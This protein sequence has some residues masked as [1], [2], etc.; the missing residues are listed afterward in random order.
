M[1]ADIGIN[2]EQKKAVFKVIDHSDKM[3]NSEWEQYATDLGINKKQLDGLKKILNDENL[4]Q[5]SEDMK[6]LFAALK[7]L[8]VDEFVRFDAHIIRGLDYYTGTVFEANDLD[9]GRALLGGGH[10]DNLVEAV[11]GEPLPAVGFAMGDV[12]ITLVLQKYGLLP[13]LPQY[14]NTCLVTVF[15]ENSLYSSY[16][17][18]AQLRTNGINTI[19]YPSAAKLL[20][21]LKFAD[22]LG[23]RY[24]ILQGT[25]EKEQGTIA[26]K[27]LKTHQQQTLPEAQFPETLKKMM[28]EEL[29]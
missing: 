2:G 16:R 11:G 4:W 27:D 1:L 14:Q 10:Y 17:L 6:R 13:E 9:G 22:K 15:D 28:N 8:S 29:I 7:A 24:V 5:K 20:K 12:M 23:I 21:Q 25:E 19:C 3:T 18:A 26:I